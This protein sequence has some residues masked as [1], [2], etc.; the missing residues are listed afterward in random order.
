MAYFNLYNL[1]LFNKLYMK[2]GKRK[3]LTEGY[4]LQYYKS[5]INT[6]MCNNIVT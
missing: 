5:V 4:L 6:E 3:Y 1:L 2:K